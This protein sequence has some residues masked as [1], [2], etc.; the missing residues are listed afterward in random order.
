MWARFKLYLLSKYV[1]YLYNYPKYKDVLHIDGNKVRIG[2]KELS[3]EERLRVIQD[4]KAISST[5]LF[6]YITDALEF[7]ATARLLNHKTPSDLIAPH[8]TVWN[9]ATMNTMIEQLRSMKN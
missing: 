5:Y 4:A 3:E 2:N 7:H 1:T 6:T 9:I 8:I